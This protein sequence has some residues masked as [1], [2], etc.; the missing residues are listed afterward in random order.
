MFCMYQCAKCGYRQEILWGT[1]MFWFGIDRKTLKKFISSE[2]K[3]LKAEVR[4]ILKDSTATVT[5]AERMGYFCPTC[6]RWE[7]H[8]AFSIQTS[9][10]N[11]TASYSCKKCLVTLQ[12]FALEERL[13]F[14]WRCPKCGGT[15]RSQE[16]LGDWD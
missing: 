6:H 5:N 10:L 11:Y 4:E 12:E 9:T 16:L 8:I 14:P 2:P 3:A 7:G 13:V 1:G 15:E